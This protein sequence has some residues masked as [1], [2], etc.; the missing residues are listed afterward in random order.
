MENRN[1]NKMSVK[2]P[3]RCPDPLG[4]G[5]AKKLIPFRGLRVSLWYCQQNDKYNQVPEGKKDKQAHDP[6][7]FALEFL[8]FAKMGTHIICPGPTFGSYKTYSNAQ[9]SWRT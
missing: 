4:S 7:K 2:S 3:L 5:A 1:D 9:A 8:L 6:G